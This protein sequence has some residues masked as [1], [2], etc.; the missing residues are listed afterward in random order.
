M[1]KNSLYPVLVLALSTT[2][3][4][5]AQADTSVDIGAGF[6]ATANNSYFTITDNTSYD[7]TNIVIT[8]TDASANLTPATWSVSD[9]S[10]NNFAVDYFAGTQGFQSNF[11]ATYAYN[12]YPGDITYEISGNLNGQ[13]L[14]TTF[15]TDSNASGRFV[16]FLGLDTF[17]N[18]T[19]T[20]DFATVASATVPVPG[21][22]YLFASGL[23]GL[24]FKR[25]K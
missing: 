8:A 1:K 9:V 13:L 14:D 21:A 11:P 12:I 25:N 5:A 23:L 4:P 19:A 17:G 20:S 3:I 7:F 16:A 24:V 2:I 18:S 15:T 10:A 22:F 6:D